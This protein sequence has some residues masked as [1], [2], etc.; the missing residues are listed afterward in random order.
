MRHFRYI[1]A[2]VILLLVVSSPLTDLPNWI[3]GFK[4]YGI[5]L[6]RWDRTGFAAQVLATA[7]VLA[8]ILLLSFLVKSEKMSIIR[9]CGIILWNVTMVLFGVFTLSVDIYAITNNFNWGECAILWAVIRV[10]VALSFVICMALFVL[11]YLYELIQRL[12]NHGTR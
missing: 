12:R 4:I 8:V 7:G 6:Y 2:F 3:A 10:F 5:S 9:K 1:M 11:G